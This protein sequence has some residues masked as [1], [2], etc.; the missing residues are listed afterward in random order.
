MAHASARAVATRAAE[1]AA[2]AAT[3]TIAGVPGLLLPQ[4]CSGCGIKM[5]QVD[6]D[7]PGYFIVPTRLIELH[8]AAQDASAQK[9]SA[10]SLDQ[11]QDQDDY[12][13][14]TAAYPD[15]VPGEDEEGADQ[16]Q[17][18]EV[19]CQR[20][21][22]L[23]H[24]GKVKV[25]AA[26]DKLPGFDLAKKVGRKI[27]L[28]KDRRAVVLVVVDAWDF[29]GSLPRTALQSLYPAGTIV[30]GELY[31]GST[32]QQDGPGADTSAPAA[33]RFQ[34][35]VALNKADLLPKQATAIRLAQWVRVRMQQAGLPRPDKVFCVSANKGSG[36]R[37]MVDTIKTAL[38]FRGDLW[39]VGA[40]NAGKSSLISAMKR[41]G[42]SSGQRDPTVAALAGT[43]LGL[44]N[45]PG[46]PLGPKQRC[47]DTP[48]VP[49]THQLTALLQPDE[50]R[51]VL[52][53]KSMQG[54]TY[55]TSAGNSVM[56]GGLARIDVLDH[57][58][59]TL[60]L[61]VWVSPYVNLHLGKTEG[62]DAR[63]LRLLGSQLSPPASAERLQELPAWEAK[64]VVVQGDA[65]DK[66]GMDVHIAGLGWV[67][68]GVK[69]Q[70]TLRVWVAPSV[71]VTTRPALVS[72]YA[73]E[74]ARPGVSVQLPGN[75]S[76]G[77]KA[78]GKAQ[79]A[80]AQGAKR[81]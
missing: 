9:S 69:G 34:L 12:A 72:D 63:L 48:G 7:G 25:E 50:V 8:E 44:I 49:H 36:V 35:M 41:L 53:G 71:A 52:P 37:D 15:S 24:T 11:D 51:L 26:E 80:K 27:A 30:P 29:D 64:D 55:R 81:Q 46:L 45:V 20:C 19:L 5:Q 13:Q 73:V 43:T 17:L 33:V 65:W 78:Q 6:T 77:A 61:T 31:G 60:Y 74:F 57:P 3:T 32:S 21:F 68:V 70:A 23:K 42:G 18:P 28:Q 56:L 40:Q 66:S 54:R 75:H 62:A 1:S 4:Y 79:S 59:A 38:G 58:G 2:A 22:S 39:V 47:F 10:P 16:E 67:A 14:A 76:T